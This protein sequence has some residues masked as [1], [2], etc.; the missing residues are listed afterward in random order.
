MNVGRLVSMLF[1][2]VLWLVLA[3]VAQA[4]PGDLDATFGS[5]GIVSSPTGITENCGWAADVAVQSDGKIVVVSTRVSKNGVRGRVLQL[6]PT[7]S[8]THRKAHR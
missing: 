4:A 5:G 8:K 3:S 7:R 6:K 2:S 1:V